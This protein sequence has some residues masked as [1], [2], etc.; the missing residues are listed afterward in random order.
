MG[1]KAP[2]PP[3]KDCAERAVGCHGKKDGEHRCK[4]YGAYMEQ[5]AACQEAKDRMYIA[6]EA[7]R[8]ARNS[9]AMYRGERLRQQLR[10]RK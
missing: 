5:M 8:Y 6:Y 3:C 1:I 10:G 4:R 9:A 7:C 2:L